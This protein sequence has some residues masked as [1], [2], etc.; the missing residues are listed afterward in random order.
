MRI[1]QQLVETSFMHPILN[2]AIKA[3]R[4]A[5]KIINRGSQD[6]GSLNI[7]MKDVNDFVSEIDQNAEAA[8]ID[9]LKDAYPDHG[10]FGEESGKSNEDAENIWIIDPL[11]G[12]TNFLHNFP[13][14]CVSIALGHF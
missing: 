10:F 6:V 11:D 7:Q 1:L 12:T 4:E 13:A 5:G 3:A 8:I 14:Y 2:V 9:I